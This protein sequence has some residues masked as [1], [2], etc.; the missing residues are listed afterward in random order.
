[1]LYYFGIEFFYVH[2]FS[3]VRETTHQVRRSNSLVAK[4]NVSLLGIENLFHLLLVFE[5]SQVHPNKCNKLT[6]KK[7]DNLERHASLF[8]MIFNLNDVQP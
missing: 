7:T 2:I 3:S 5:K 1:M 4:P 6:N 8:V